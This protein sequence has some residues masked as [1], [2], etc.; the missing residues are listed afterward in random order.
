MGTWRWRCGV[1]DG[2]KEPYGSGSDSG[3]GENYPG[4]VKGR[5][6]MY[7]G[8]ERHVVWCQLVINV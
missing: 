3:V 6:S 5:D 2:C 4:G 7:L 1:V 8:Y